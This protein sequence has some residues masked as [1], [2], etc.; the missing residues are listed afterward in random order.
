MSVGQALPA[1]TVHVDR[2]R[3]VQYAGAALGRNPIHWD[4]RFAVS[5][6]LPDVI[7]HGMFTMGSVIEIV[8]AWVGDAGR[9]VEY[10]SLIHI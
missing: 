5:V 7:A 10:L 3:L 1:L 6:G 2:A 4:E 8:S 9:V